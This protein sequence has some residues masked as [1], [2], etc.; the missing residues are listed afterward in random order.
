MGYYNYIKVNYEINDHLD[1]QQVNK[2][3]YKFDFLFDWEKNTTDFFI[4]G[5]YKWSSPFHHGTNKYAVGQGLT[6]EFSG[7]DSLILYTL[8]PGGVSEFM[9]VKLCKERC[10]EETNLKNANLL[11]PSTKLLMATLL[12]YL[13]MLSLDEETKCEAKIKH[14]IKRNKRVFKER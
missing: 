4:N 2:K 5:K 11:G 14:E 1:D 7:V 8:T 10:I 9:D 3:W 12:I 6:P 13:S